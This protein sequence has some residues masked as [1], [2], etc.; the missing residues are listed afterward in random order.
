MFICCSGARVIAVKSIHQPRNNNAW[1]LM[2]CDLMRR[3]IYRALVKVAISQ[4]GERRGV[5][6][7]PNKRRRLLCVLLSG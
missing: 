5:V 4:H 6:V 1:G 3:L 7:G 2:C